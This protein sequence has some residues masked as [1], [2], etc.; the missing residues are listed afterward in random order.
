MNRVATPSVSRRAASGGTAANRSYRPP[1]RP[2]LL[3][4]AFAPRR[5]TAS[6]PTIATATT[7]PSTSSRPV[8]APV[9]LVG[10][11]VPPGTGEAA[12]LPDGAADALADGLGAAAASVSSV[13]PIGPNWNSGVPPSTGWFCQP[14]KWSVRYACSSDRSRAGCSGL[15]DR[16]SPASPAASPC[17]GSRH[18]SGPAA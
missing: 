16:R 13:Y 5:R 18:S 10:E 4:V 1:A 17:A 8:F 7:A 15:R 9:S 6:V 12:A 2:S 14:P 3:S 11:P